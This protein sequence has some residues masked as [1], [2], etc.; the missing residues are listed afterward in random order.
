MC[1]CH[2]SGLLIGNW[3]FVY[4]GPFHNRFKTFSCKYYC[5]GMVLFIMR[6]SVIKLIPTL[7]TICQHPSRL[8]SINALSINF[9]AGSRW[10]CTLNRAATPVLEW[11]GLGDGIGHGSDSTVK[12]AVNVII[13]F[14]IGVLLSMALISVKWQMIHWC[15]CVFFLVT[16]LAILIEPGKFEVV[17]IWVWFVWFCWFRQLPICSDCLW[18]LPG[19]TK[20]SKGAVLL[21]CLWSMVVNWGLW[22]RMSRYYR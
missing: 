20:W 8:T 9:G 2:Y 7:C 1:L 10:T 19:K 22:S 4:I 17:Y 21:I 18:L 11:V 12:M 16:I 3:L 14:L 6:D 5:L 13:V 15:I